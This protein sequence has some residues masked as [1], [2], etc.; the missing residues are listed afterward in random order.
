MIDYLPIFIQDYVEIKA[1]MDAEQVS[2]V[3]AW[4]DAEDVMCDQFI[5]DLTENGVKRWESIL[6]IVP[7]S[8][9]T[10]DERRFNILARLSE[11]I[12]YTIETLKNMLSTMCGEDGYTIRL[13][14]N[15]YLLSVKLSL[16]N[17]N[18]VDA[19]ENLLYR[20]VPANIVTTVSL[21]NTH[22]ALSALTHEQL[23]AYT[24]YQ[25]RVETI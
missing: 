11:Q 1:I 10:L 23:S 25:V 15:N 8:T 9:Y 21:F 12:P 19:V 17:E 7:K 3:K 4:D 16:S 6:E 20:I 14:H 2:V 13:D 22:A 5:L 24:Q 18:N